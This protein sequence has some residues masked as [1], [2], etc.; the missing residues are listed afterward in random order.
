MIKKV[1]KIIV[2]GMLVATLA[3]CGKKDA[4]NTEK[5]KDAVY[6]NLSEDKVTVNGETI[7]EYDYV[8]N[9][10]PSTE[11]EWYSGEEPDASKPVYIAHDI[12]Y[13]PELPAE[14][15]SKENY[16]GETEWVYHYE[17]EDLKDFIF[18]TLP[19]LRGKDGVPT[20]MMHSVSEAYDN[21]VLHICEPGTYVL[22]GTWHG[23]IF[24]DLG[25]KDETFIDEKAK[26]T[27]VL[28]GV[29]VTCDVAPAFIV[30][31]AYECDNKWE[32]RE[33]YSGNVNTADAGANVIIADGTKNNFTGANIYRLLKAKY[34]KEGSTVQKKA[35]KIDGAFY[36][37]VSMN[38]NGEKNDTGILNIRS[39]TFE[40]M[41]SEL[42]LTINGGN[43]T[44]YSQDDGINV[45]EDNVSVFTMNE[46]TLHIFAGLGAEGDCVDSNGFITI[47]GGLIAAGTPS[48]ADTVLDSD[49]GNTVNGG[50]VLE[51]GS[52]TG[53]GNL[54]GKGE[55]G[56][57]EGFNHRRD[58]ENEK[59]IAP[60]SDFEFD[61]DLEPG[62]WFGPGKDI[63]PGDRGELPPGEKEPPVEE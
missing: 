30:N 28:N 38:I 23:Q 47:N 33:N 57:G 17:K 2:L 54:G 9:I 21:P 50:E 18:S 39:T 59:G 25:D 49:K 35:H 43:I 7:P 37:F 13:Y 63:N 40:G 32:E 55:F 26:V 44:V 45:N 34:K 62:E 56:P 6:V 29:D 51:I 41:G 4:E 24:V 15:F 52:T 58:F 12:W 22:S 5:Y 60:G 36:S 19:V 31:S 20:E 8:W 61:K 1:A 46:G 10:N 42:H 11:A 3:A 48:A 16:D 27:I 14:G 53:V